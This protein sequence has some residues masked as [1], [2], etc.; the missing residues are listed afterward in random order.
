MLGKRLA[1]ERYGPPGT[2]ANGARAIEAWARAQGVILTAKD[3]SG[4]SYD[5]RVSPAGIA[6][7]LG[8]AEA[9]EWGP[10]LRDLLPG[11]GEG[12]LEDRLNGVRVHAKTGTLDGVSALSGWVW[13]RRPQSWAEFSILSRGM[14]KTTAVD[15][16]NEV[17]RI[18]TR[19]AN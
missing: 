8:S 16:E 6:R 13:L 17:V 14:A 3:S 5:N 2:I 1:V 19:E 18:L 9:F 11:P 10:G 7:L 4:L 12:T 15:I